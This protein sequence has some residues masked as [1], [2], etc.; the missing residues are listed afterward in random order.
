[1]MKKLLSILM[2]AVLTATMFASCTGGEKTDM[3]KIGVV[4]IVEHK[5]LDS[6]RDSFK[7]QLETLGYVEGENCE[8][9]YKSAQGDQNNLNTIIQ[10]FAGDEVDVIVAIAT[11][12]AQAAATVADKIPVVFS[13]VT[14]PVAAGLVT[15]MAKPDKN[16]TGTSDA[17]QV[18]KI[19][20]FALSVTPDVKKIG[21]LYNTGEA[22]SV[23]NLQKTK[24]FAE[25]K[26]IEVIEGVATNT[27]EVQTAV[28]VLA[29]QVDIMFVPNDNTIASAMAVVTKVTRE[30][31]VPVYT[32]A[33]SMVSDGGFATVGIDYTDL[34]KETANI[35]DMVLKGTAVADIPVMV[36]A[37][38]L[39]TYINETTANEIGVTVPDEI[40]NAEKTVIM[41]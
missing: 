11:P 27:S 14:D 8:V 41:K 37:D 17:V 26:G 9:Q 20:D 12:T 4:Q 23:S 24:A 29:D 32:G 22:N 40:L 36:F 28:E 19:L 13:A 25:A 6:I 33:D 2:A 18:E 5:S 38:D 21:F 34:G 10:S 7:A 1:M 15:D 3:T 31:K 16:I 30:A 39:N 35:T